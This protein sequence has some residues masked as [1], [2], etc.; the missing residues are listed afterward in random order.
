ME[1]PRNTT[2]NKEKET[3]LIPV[4]S[5]LVIPGGSKL[6]A[7]L[8]LSTVTVCEQKGTWMVS[9]WELRKGCPDGTCREVL[10]LPTPEF[11]GS[12]GEAQ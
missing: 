4:G 11:P 6:E 5:C 8:A 1:L 9:Q 7:T 12:E 2:R 10:T 3:H